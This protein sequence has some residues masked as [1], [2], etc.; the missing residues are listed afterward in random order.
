MLNFR[1]PFHAD[2]ILS[3]SSGQTSICINFHIPFHAD[4]ISAALSG[5][6]RYVT[7]T[8]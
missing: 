7:T 2:I 3:A 4:V 1:S 6:I 8:K 5:Q